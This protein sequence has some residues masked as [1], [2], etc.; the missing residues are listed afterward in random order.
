MTLW[1]KQIKLW[2]PWTTKA[3]KAMIDRK[4]NNKK[5][6]KEIGISESYVTSALCGYPR[7]PATVDKISDYLNIPRQ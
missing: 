1:Q 6:A 7:S 3:R 4:L 2:E 5:L